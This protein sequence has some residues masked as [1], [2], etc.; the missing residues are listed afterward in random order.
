MSTFLVSALEIITTEISIASI[1]YCMVDFINRLCITVEAFSGFPSNTI[2]I[3]VEL[4]T[5]EVDVYVRQVVLYIYGAFNR[6]VNG[7]YTVDFDCVGN[8]T[9]VSNLYIPKGSTRKSQLEYTLP[10]Y[11]MPGM[12][13]GVLKIDATDLSSND[14][15]QG[16]YSFPLVYVRDRSYEELKADYEELMTEYGELQK[17]YEEVVADFNELRKEYERISRLEAELEGEV[18]RNRYILYVFVGLTVALT[19]TLLYLAGRR[20]L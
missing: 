3:E 13:H 12:T 19:L 7:W 11:I 4:K 16:R 2:T 15:M 1:G 5:M 9:L 17:Q 20:K 14:S 8:I 6:N 10:Y 18:E